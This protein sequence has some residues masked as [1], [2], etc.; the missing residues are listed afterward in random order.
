MSLKGA[1]I[2]LE[3]SFTHPQTL[4]LRFKAANLV[5]RGFFLIIF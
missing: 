2:F 5:W 3:F 1:V 4:L